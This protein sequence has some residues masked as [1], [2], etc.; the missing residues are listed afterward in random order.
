MTWGRPFGIAVG[1][2]PHCP[3]LLTSLVPTGIVATVSCVNVGS[4]QYPSI[5]LLPTNGRVCSNS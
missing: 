2:R 4:E 5:V 1:G 3:A